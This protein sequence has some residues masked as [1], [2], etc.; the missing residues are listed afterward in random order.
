MAG[1]Q[2][3]TTRAQA[4]LR[5]A[6]RSA[7]LGA[8]ARRARALNSVD[9]IVDAGRALTLHQGGASFTVQHVVEK[10]GVALQTFYRHF[11]SKDELVLA[12]FEEAA[13]EGTAE[14]A[15]A[16]DAV[17][18]PVQRLK[19]IVTWAALPNVSV[20]RLTA[21]TM[22][23]EHLRLY[24]SFPKE[25]EGALLPFRQLI[26]DAIRAAQAAGEF[27]GIDAEID[28]ELI[29]QLIISRFHLR[30]M[31]VLTDGSTSAADN[32]WTFCLG[33]LRR[34]QTRPR[35]RPSLRST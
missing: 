14:M 35:R 20:P 24:Q 4:R 5:I 21:E 31:G 12:I 32:L 15:K 7:A 3:G 28:A 13:S 11:R 19:L 25:V 8:E 33:A 10:A 9:R 22:V 34:N 2:R 17:L 1:S 30:A 26:V 29:H 18:D 27:P 6:D 16:A 23:K